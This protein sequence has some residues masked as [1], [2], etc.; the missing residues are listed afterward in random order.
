[1]VWDKL[2]S[3]GMRRTDVASSTYWRLMPSV[4]QPITE[5]DAGFLLP[6]SGE[7]WQEIR[8]WHR[9]CLFDN[10]FGAEIATR[11]EKHAGE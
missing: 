9:Y 3:A 6:Y 7:G 11:M 5:R 1:M 2:G 4:W 10:L 8:P